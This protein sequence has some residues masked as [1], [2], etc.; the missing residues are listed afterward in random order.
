MIEQNELFFNT[1]NKIYARKKCILTVEYFVKYAMGCQFIF[2][3]L[4]KIMSPVVFVQL[5]LQEKIQQK[6]FWKVFYEYRNEKNY[7]TQFDVQQW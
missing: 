2:L 7:E 6:L 3:Q 4:V 1:F 5:K